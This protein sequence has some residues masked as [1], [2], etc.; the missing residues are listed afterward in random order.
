MGNAQGLSI[1]HLTK[2]IEEAKEEYYLSLILNRKT[3]QKILFKIIKDLLHK[4]NPSTFSSCVSDRDLALSFGEFFYQKVQDI[5]PRSTQT[6]MPLSC[7]MNI[8]QMYL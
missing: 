2:L 5:L 1:N 3:D 6:D 7:C 4:N 8:F